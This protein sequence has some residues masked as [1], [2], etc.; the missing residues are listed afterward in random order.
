MLVSGV[1]WINFKQSLC[2]SVW[3]LG[4]CWKRLSVESQA[5]LIT[6]VLWSLCA[7]SHPPGDNGGIY[8]MIKMQPTPLIKLTISARLL[9]APQHYP[10]NLS[11]TY[12]NMK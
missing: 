10:E 11:Q 4:G 12:K 9:T 7:S 2:N 5:D 6:E 8:S 3:P 1:K